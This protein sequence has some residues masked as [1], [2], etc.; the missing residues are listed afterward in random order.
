M[1]ATACSLPFDT[2]LSTPDQAMQTQLANIETRTGK[3]PSQLF[4]IL[5][6]AGCLAA[7]RVRRRRRV[8]LPHRGETDALECGLS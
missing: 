1:V 5:K 6:K 7:A 3:K 4:A 8:G 2:R